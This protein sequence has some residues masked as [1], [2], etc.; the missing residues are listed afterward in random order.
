MHFDEDHV[1]EFRGVSKRFQERIVLSDASFRIDRGTI[2]FLVGRSGM[3]KSVCLKLMVGLLKQDSG[4]ILFDGDSTH[5]FKEDDWMALRRRLSLIFQNPALLDSMTLLDNLRLPLRAGGLRRSR[6]EEDILI[7]GALDQ[8]GLTRDNLHKRP[9]EV[10]LGTQRRASI[11][12]ALVLE[13]ECLLFDEPTTGLDP[14][15]TA[16]IN[17]LIGELGRM[18]KTILVVSHDL[19]CALAIADRIL[20]LDDGKM[21]VD[22]TPERIREERHSLLSDFLKEADARVVQ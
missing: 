19:H 2:T 1:I 5:A 13:S 17:N 16:R 8:V 14:V 9:L 10:S 4:E 7:Q 18:G 11:A 20:F 6:G 3:G 21:V 22:T 15:H 12:R